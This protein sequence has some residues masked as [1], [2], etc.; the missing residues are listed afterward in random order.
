MAVDIIILVIVGILIAYLIYMIGWTKGS[1]YSDDFLNW[2][3]G[4]DSG[5]DTGWD[6]GFEVGYRRGLQGL[7]KEK[8]RLKEQDEET[9]G[10]G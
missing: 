1:F 8:E 5:W 7:E 2:S 6:L 4:F 9:P 10:E 3:H